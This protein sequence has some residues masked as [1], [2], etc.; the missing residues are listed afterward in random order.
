[1]GANLLGYRDGGRIAA[2]ERFPLRKAAL[3]EVPLI[4]LDGDEMLPV[5][6]LPTYQVP[7]L[8]LDR[9]SA[10]A[11]CRQSACP[12]AGD[13]WLRPFRDLS[14]QIEA[15]GTDDRLCATA[16]PTEACAGALAATRGWQLEL[17][18]MIDQAGPASS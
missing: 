2:D 8:L 4:V 17:L 15:H 9:L 3:Y 16:Q 11:Y 18:R 14:L 10:G 6:R 1:L 12:W 13:W 7:Y 5:G